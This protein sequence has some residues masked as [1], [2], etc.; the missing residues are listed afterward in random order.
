VAQFDCWL[1]WG[2]VQL[3]AYFRNRTAIA[4]SNFGGLWYCSVFL[5]FDQ[6]LALA[7]GK[8]VT[9]QELIAE[10]CVDAIVMPI[11][12]W[13]AGLWKNGHLTAWSLSIDVSP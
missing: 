8:G 10:S 12:S 6:K 7:S 5:F 2:L 3:N 4:A 11:T 9:V 13:T 1:E